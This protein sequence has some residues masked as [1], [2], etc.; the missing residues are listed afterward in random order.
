MEQADAVGC[1][2]GYSG[3]VRRW[4]YSGERERES[5]WM[6]NKCKCVDSLTHDTSF[7]IRA[8]DRTSIVASHGHTLEH[9]MNH[10]AALSG[11]TLAMHEDSNEVPC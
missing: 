10:R 2:W 4:G 9:M 6:R 8:T 7:V 11:S 1:G 3:G 5:Q